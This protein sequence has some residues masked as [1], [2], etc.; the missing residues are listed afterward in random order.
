MI[1][2]KTTWLEF[3][4]RDQKL[5]VVV[6]A[7][8]VKSLG[9]LQRNGSSWGI[10]QRINYRKSGSG[11]D[12]IIISRISLMDPQI[13]LKNTISSTSSSSSDIWPRLQLSFCE[14]AS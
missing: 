7:W 8:G 11:I 6:E 4:W 1:Y 5:E 9:G 3:D 2:H 14:V 10:T 13:L 12:G